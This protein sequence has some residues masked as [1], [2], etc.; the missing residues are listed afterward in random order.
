MSTKAQVHDGTGLTTIVLIDAVAN[1][2]KHHYEWPDEW[3]G[4]SRAHATID[5]VRK[6]G[7]E[8]NHEGNLSHAVRELGMT[9]SDLSPMSTMIQEWRERLAA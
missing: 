6:L 4:S 3:T 7:F 5:I 1:Y 2:F 8:P 9:E